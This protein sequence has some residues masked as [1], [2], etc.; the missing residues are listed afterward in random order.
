MNIQNYDL[1]RNLSKQLGKINPNFSNLIFLCIGTDKIIGDSIGPI[2]G[3]KLKEIENNYIK[4][5]G[6]LEKNLDFL[7]TKSM[8]ENIYKIYENPFLITIDAAL[9]RRKNIGE[10]F[11][12]NGYIKLGNALEKS[13]CYYSNINIKCVVGEYLDKKT[14]INILKKVDKIKIYN[15]AELLTKHIKNIVKK[16][17]VYV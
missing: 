8:L 6:T 9:S 3:S 15:M 5:Y 16:M 17:Q 12:T 2:V 10:I 4:I 11:V 7:N 14:N 13:I 1:K